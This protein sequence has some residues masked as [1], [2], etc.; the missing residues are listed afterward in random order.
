MTTKTKKVVFQSGQYAVE[1]EEYW[2]FRCQATS[3]SWN[4]LKG[5]QQVTTCR[6]LKDAKRQVTERIAM[7]V[8]VNAIDQYL[9]TVELE[10]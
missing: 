8:E 6:R 10:A 3:V 2:G 5:G 1:R 9:R 7:D 4:V